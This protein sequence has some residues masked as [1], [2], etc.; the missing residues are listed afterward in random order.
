VVTLTYYSDQQLLAAFE[1]S[2]FDTELTLSYALA[3][4]SED[5]W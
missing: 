2:L 3:D 5:K 1:P 4:K